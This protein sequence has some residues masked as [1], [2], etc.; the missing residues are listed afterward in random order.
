MLDSSNAVEAIG[1]WL[2][3]IH[4]L[5]IGPGLGRDPRVLQN[6]EM[7]IKLVIEL[8]IPL[9]ID[10]DGLFYINNNYQVIQ[11]CINVILTPNAA[12]FGRLFK[13]VM[14]TNLDRTQ[15][16]NPDDVIA[17][18]KRLGHVTILVKGEKDI[19]T[20]GVDTNI[21]Y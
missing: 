9:V 11:G 19:I 15:S 14:G 5:I 20:N 6:I 17:L 18:A 3:R 1:E 10:A 12:E 21:W 4:S 16:T 8:D 7:I 13:S 2:P